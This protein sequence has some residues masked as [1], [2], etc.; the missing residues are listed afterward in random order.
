MNLPDNNII[1]KEYK[2]IL[3]KS[4]IEQ[5]CL[6][7]KIDFYSVFLPDTNNVSIDLYEGYTWE[8]KPNSMEGLR[9]GL[10]IHAAPPLSKIETF[11]WEE[12]YVYKNKTYHAILYTKKKENF[13][14]EVMIKITDKEH[15]ETVLGRKWYFFFDESLIPFLF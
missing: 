1:K 6:K 4:D 13:E 3:K 14:G 12:W 2:N 7:L 9:E 5:A 10:V 15:P 11:P 8:V